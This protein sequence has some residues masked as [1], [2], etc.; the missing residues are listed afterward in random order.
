MLRSAALLA[1]L[2]AAGC[3]SV[4]AAPPPPPAPVISLD[5]KIAWILRL[6]QQRVLAD[7]DEPP[8]G[9]VPAQAAATPAPTPGRE[10]GGARPSL[11]ADLAAL[12]RDPDPLVR[13][14]AVTAIGR[15]G[16]PEGV[17]PAAA[18]LQDPDEEVRASAAFALGLLGAAEPIDPPESVKANA[19]G[20]AGTGPLL[21]ALQDP[22]LL[23]Q[24]RAI[25]A[26][27]LVG[28]PG[29][30]GAVAQAA[31]GCAP[32]LAAIA[33]DDEVW[34]K[35]WE[36]EVCRLAL[37]A[38]VRLQDYGALAAVALD[39]SGRPVSE[40]WPVAYALQ[41]INDPRAAPALRAL[42]ASAGV[43]TAG[44][45]VRGL[46]AL[47]DPSVAAL[48]T[49]L[50]QRQDADL[51]LRIAAVRALGQTRTTGPLRELLVAPALPVPLLIE[52]VTAIGAAQ[53]RASFD[54]LL[55]LLTHSSPA[56]RAAALR[57]SAR[58]YPEGFLVVLSG[59]GRDPHWS[60]R[61]ALAG[62]LATL[63]PDIA[64]AGIESLL[65]DPDIRVHGAALEALAAIKAPGL[66]TRLF[67]A[68]EAN[69]YV[70]RATAARLIGEA[71]PDGGVPRLT[72][73]Y[74][75]ARNDST[76]VAR[77]A[78]LEAL[79]KYGGPEAIAPLRE[80]LA[81]REWPVRWRAARLLAGLGESEARPER[82][83]PL[84][85][86]PEF[87]TSDRLLHPQFSPRAFIE[88][89][90]GML[91][92]QL[93]VVEAAVTSQIFIDQARAGFFN[94]MAIHR[95]VPAFVVQAGD[96]RGDGEGGPGYTIRDELSPVPYLRGTMGMA[97]DWRDTAGSQ[98]FIATSP[99]PH[100]DGRYT[101][102]GRVVT[103]VEVLDRLAPWDVI[104]R[105]R[106]WDGV[107]LQ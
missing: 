54:V 68:L 80:A 61:A 17:A 58:S 102:F 89:A 13:R 86:P 72:A 5:Q 96:P 14:R 33:A 52:I 51:K 69:D 38:L 105:I 65:D 106:I 84:A 27:G 64:T 71:R 92:V 103:N 42:A 43:Y 60:V 34:P 35:T 94:G 55:D 87:F 95:V 99:Q 50:A 85:R 66:A 21:A 57:A 47:K 98:W 15:V 40:W 4:P 91:E 32:R 7:P 78:A 41:R 101:V 107:T 63:S 24:A 77:W 23:V 31:A 79:A 20:Y 49:I 48:A 62:V 11:R 93:N 28:N 37:F 88:T 104:E 30:A 16:M 82:P 10:P 2:I 39:P 74:A 44:F 12:A 1:L 67:A 18:A 90:A 36:V 8:A 6:E 3:A 75:Q 29:V 45:A 81:D 46:A 56:V 9:A 100:L 83:A 53:D 73:A 22:S 97:L 19:A 59:L 25:D 70:V 76:Y 26:L